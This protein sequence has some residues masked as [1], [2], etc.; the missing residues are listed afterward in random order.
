[1]SL[2]ILFFL[3]GSNGNEHLSP[4]EA[5]KI[6]ISTFVLADVKI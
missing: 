6:Q 4:N 3:Y 2:E 1:M 5:I